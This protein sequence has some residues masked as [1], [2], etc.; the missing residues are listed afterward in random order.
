MVV[1][2]DTIVS[3]LWERAD[4]NSEPEPE[5]NIRVMVGCV[6]NLIDVEH[7]YLTTKATY[8]LVTSF[9]TLVQYLHAS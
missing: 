5:M 8:R 2:Q 6:K 3:M 4:K 9:L 1:K 7:D